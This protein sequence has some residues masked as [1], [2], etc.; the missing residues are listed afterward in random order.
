MRHDDLT[1]VAEC[2]VPAASQLVQ[3]GGYLEDIDAELSG[4]LTGIRRAP[5]PGERLVHREPQVLTVHAAIVAK[6]R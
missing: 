3:A 2:Q 1:P 6:A 5:G 4:Q